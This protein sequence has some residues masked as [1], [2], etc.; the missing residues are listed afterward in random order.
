MTSMLWLANA[1]FSRYATSNE[2]ATQK[3]YMA[4]WSS[5]FRGL[6]YRIPIYI[7]PAYDVHLLLTP[8]R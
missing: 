6:S 4:S 2:K 3:T 1:L 8:Q 5:A 7:E